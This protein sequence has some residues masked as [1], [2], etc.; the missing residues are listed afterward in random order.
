ML[1]F[2]S[3]YWLIRCLLPLPISNISFFCFVNNNLLSTLAHTHGTTNSIEWFSK[4]R[5][6]STRCY[7]PLFV[8]SFNNKVLDFAIIKK[9]PY[10][11]FSFAVNSNCRRDISYFSFIGKIVANFQSWVECW[12]G[13]TSRKESTSHWRWYCEWWRNQMQVDEF[14]YLCHS[15]NW[16][17]KNSIKI[18]FNLYLAF[19]SAGNVVRIHTDADGILGSTYS[20]S[21]LTSASTYG[22]HTQIECVCVW[23]CMFS[24]AF[25]R[26]WICK[27]KIFLAMRFIYTYKLASAKAKAKIPLLYANTF[28]IVTKTGKKYS[29]NETVS[30]A[31]YWRVW[32][33]RD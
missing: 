18:T 3:F 7:L 29:Q 21:L 16:R 22:A 1:A 6:R 25:P 12:S 23:V 31:T 9:N 27:Q 15:K 19:R 32:L 10:I 24:F 13:S 8:A 28:Y 33:A 4:C 17:R 2:N 5:V 14:R 30:T 26:L 11:F 20:C